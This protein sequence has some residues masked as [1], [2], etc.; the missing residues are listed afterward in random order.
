M[1]N[2]YVLPLASRFGLLRHAGTATILLGASLS[3]ASAADVTFTGT[4]VGASWFIP[5]NWSTGALPTTTDTATI[6]AGRD[7]L[8][9]TGTSS[10]ESLVIS[11][12]SNL[13]LDGANALLNITG[14]WNG[15]T[16]L[17]TIVQSGT[18]NIA[19]GAR[20]T[21]TLSDVNI[22]QSGTGTLVISSGGTFDT[23]IAKLGINAGDIGVATVTGPNSTWRVNSGLDVGIAG[24]GTV[25]I[26]NG[27]TV[28]ASSF[29]TV[30]AGT[31]GNGTIVVSGTGSTW[32]SN[33]NS[34]VVGAGT[35]SVGF[36]RLENG[37]KI[38]SSTINQG[39]FTL[40]D[41]AGS[42]GTVIQT[43]GTATVTAVM[44]GSGTGIYRLEGGV[45][46]AADFRE[47]AP[48]VG[49]YTLELAGGTI[50]SYNGNPINGEL[51]AT[52]RQGTTSSIDITSASAFTT[53]TW[54]GVISGSGA[55]A[56][57]GVGTFIIGGNNSYSGGTTLTA[58]S[59][60]FGHNNAL[61]SGTLAINGNT[62][63]GASGGART[64][65]NNVALGSGFTGTVTGNVNLTLNGTV[66][67]AGALRKI[68]TG[69]LTLSS[70]NSYTGSTSL[71]AGTILIGNNNALG[72]G[73][74]AI[75]GNSAFGSTGASVTIANSLALG[76]TF[77]GTVLGTTNLELSGTISGAGALRKT[78]TGTLTLSGNNSY[79]GG[80]TL[81]QGAILV[82]HNNA[83]GSGALTIGGN[84]SFGSTGASRTI[85]NNISI[86]SGFT[87][88]NIGATDLEL[89][90]IISGAGALAKAGTGALVVSGTNNTYT[91]KTTVSSGTLVVITLA[92]LN[93]NSSLGGPTTAANGTI[94]IGAAG[95][96]AALKYNGAGSTS[97]RTINQAGST[98][99]A[100]LDASGSGA[101]VLTGS[102]SSAAGN[103]TLTLTGTS[104][105]LNTISGTIGNG[106]TGVV[107]L[108]K[109]GAGTWAL[110]AAN[111]YSGSTTISGGKLSIAAGNNLGSATSAV[112]LGGAATS[113]TL[114]YSG[115]TASYTRGFS[116]NAGGGGLETT[117]AGQTLTLSTG[118]IATAG[119]FTVSG[120]GNTA[121]TSTISGTGSL[122]KTGSGRLAVSGNNS[123]TGGTTVTSGTLSVQHNDALGTGAVNVGGGTLAVESGFGIGNSVVLSGGTYIRTLNGSLIDAANASSD[124]NGGVD[125]SARIA[126]GATATSLTLTTSFSATS[127][128][129]NDEIRRSDVYAFAG[130]DDSLFVME[131]SYASTQEGSYLGWLDGDEWV[132]ATAGNSDNNATDDMLNYQ[133][134]FADFQ[135]EY[136]NSLSSYVGAYGVDIS[137]GVTTTWAVLNHNS[138]FSVI[139]EPGTIALLAT[140]LAALGLRRRSRR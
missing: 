132:N 73:T 72:S 14:S 124:L 55:L 54:T 111:T 15:T 37:G 118:G 66:S 99:G 87:G 28:S 48:G 56:K 24:S 16:A 65:A 51:N 58:G 29:T 76:S 107:S 61:G 108:E 11:G 57:I 43:G 83:L 64:I 116:V 89:S 50:R 70:S 52:L 102:I 82:G 120:S 4:G 92:N 31:G 97:N 86:G 96:S 25:S 74:L 53:G 95:T 81:S 27:G 5:A 18:L 71:T 59:L 62:A 136:G 34:M 12:T 100:V 45:L 119:R 138:D 128:A 33:G 91:G 125:T 69:T 7:A 68:G 75:T 32:D 103:K 23:G 137:G 122:Q 63:F 46:E 115:N 26:L 110:S 84:S 123:Y 112:V 67:G 104:E 94:D 109:S 101:L 117:T 36:V 130:T 21:G 40:G 47:Y 127:A 8:L 6:T 79:S 77:T 90:G 93:A 39:Q 20:M 30:G 3:A 131:L 38:V 44:I 10:V 135:L 78:S 133:G 42:L 134:S 2:P 80:T 9:G 129:A 114:A 1:E 121:I 98:G 105:A 17:K 113:G 126:A 140:G 13:S 106:S 35:N 60:L 41:V 139:P 85:A 22:G 88:T 49:S 19:N